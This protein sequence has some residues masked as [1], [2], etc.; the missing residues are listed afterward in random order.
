MQLRL[1]VAA[2]GKLQQGRQ[3]GQLIALSASLAS[4]WGDSARLSSLKDRLTE[5]ELDNN[6]EP[7]QP[8]PS[9]IWDEGLVMLKDEN[10]ER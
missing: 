2:L 6:I 5:L 9:K 8:V 10:M 4:D 3:E 1:Q 7:E